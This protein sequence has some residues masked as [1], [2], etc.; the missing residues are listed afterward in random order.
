MCVFSFS[1]AFSSPYFDF[2]SV[3]VEPKKAVFEVAAHFSF[4]LF[5]PGPINLAHYQPNQSPPLL[6]VRQAA[7]D[8]LQGLANC[9]LFCLTTAKIR[10]LV[11]R[12]TR[13]WCSCCSTWCQRQQRRL[14]EEKWMSQP[15]VR[16]RR[17]I[18]KVSKRRSVDGSDLDIS[19]ISLDLPS[20][21]EDL[22]EVKYTEDEVLFE[23]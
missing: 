12:T 18:A 22:E 20:T 6:C 1:L 16:M 21:S 13:R 9:I 8:N 4:V 2:L 17:G 19:G 5:L 15:I 10:R 14:A 23:R 11:A 7:G 3:K